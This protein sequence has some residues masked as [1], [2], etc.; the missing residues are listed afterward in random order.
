MCAM[1]G[2]TKSS[3]IGLP[4]FAFS[5]EYV[6]TRRSRER[7]CP[8]TPTM[9]LGWVRICEASERERERGRERKRRRRSKRERKGQQGFFYDAPGPYI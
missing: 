2:K 5:E 9:V 7:Q 3:A 1:G 4:F 6:Q 8:A